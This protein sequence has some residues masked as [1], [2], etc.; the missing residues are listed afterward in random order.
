MRKRTQSS[1]SS[2]CA[3]EPSNTATACNVV[4]PHDKQTSPRQGTDPL[5]CDES[6]PA[7]VIRST[8]LSGTK[9]LSCSQ[10]EQTQS[11]EI[12]RSNISRASL[13]DGGIEKVLLPGE[14]LLPRVVAAT[15]G[16]HGG[17]FRPAKSICAIANPFQIWNS[18]PHG[19]ASNA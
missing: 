15:L 13:R 19:G 12:L 9:N 5:L 6:K 10:T 8:K 11:G 4:Y 14:V 18:Q 2:F 16:N 17:K 7:R 1:S 3:S